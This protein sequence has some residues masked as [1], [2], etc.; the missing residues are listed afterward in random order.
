MADLGSFLLARD[1]MAERQALN[2]IALRAQEKNEKASSWQGIGGTM[3]GLL[4]PILL[5]A[6]GPVGI[7]LAAAAGTLG[8][9]L[10]GRGAAGG[11]ARGTAVKGGKFYQPQ[12]ENMYDELSDFRSDM[13]EGLILNSIKS[14]VA[15][16]MTPE[17]FGEAKDWLGSDNKFKN[18][19]DLFNRGQN[20]PPAQNPYSNPVP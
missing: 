9:G 2:D 8:G 18:M 19:F 15:Y 12:R 11:P 6:T 4:L 14:G 13:N 1:R 10:L 7:G 17:F 5:G 16:G 20:V 3:G